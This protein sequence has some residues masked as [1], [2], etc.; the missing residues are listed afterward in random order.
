[1]PGRPAAKRAGKDYS[2]G[3]EPDDRWREHLQEVEINPPRLALTEVNAMSST[4][5][6]SQRET[7]TNFGPSLP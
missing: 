4:D 5:S 3:D 1:L 7:V 2:E 6:L